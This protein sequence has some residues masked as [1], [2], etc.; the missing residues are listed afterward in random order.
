VPPVAERGEHLV[1]LRRADSSAK[2][3]RVLAALDA[4][5]AAGES[6]QPAVLAR[7]AGVSRRFIY[8]HPELRAEAE[9]RAVEVTDRLAAG[10]AAS[11]RVTTASLRA[12]LENAKALNHRLES[13]LGELLG[14]QV[15]ADDLAAGSTRAQSDATGARI[16]E[17]EQMLFEAREALAQ[18]TEEL[19]AARQINRELMARLN[20]GG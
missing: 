8:D 7:K 19:E 4:M 11:I 10:T 18:S 5:V 12:D 9:R 2:A 3:A 17:L 14:H 15:M 20:R 16:A 6:P 1:R 13:Q